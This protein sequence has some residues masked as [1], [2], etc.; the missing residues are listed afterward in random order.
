[1][2]F[3]LYCNT[4]KILLAVFLPHSTHTLQPLDVVIFGPLSAAYSKQLSRYL[5]NSQGFL[6]IKKGSFFA[7]FWMA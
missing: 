5:Y 6:H 4:H 3:I 2:G 7:L 1:M